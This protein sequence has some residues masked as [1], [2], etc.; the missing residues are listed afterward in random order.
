VINIEIYLD[1]IKDI[2]AKYAVYGINLDYLKIN[3]EPRLNIAVAIVGKDINTGE[4]ACGIRIDRQISDSAISSAKG[5]IGYNKKSNKYDP[6][7]MDKATKLD[8]DRKFIQH[9]ILHE[10]A[11]HKGYTQEEEY[12]CDKWAF[13]E[14]EELGW[15]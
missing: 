11:H 4:K 2:M 7:L 8:T 5:A 12:E 3:D 15:L 9:L 10:I 14:M 6:T 1:E 13:S